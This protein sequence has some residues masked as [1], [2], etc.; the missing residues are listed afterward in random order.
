MATKRDYL[1]SLGLAKPGRG[2]FS[3]EAT[4]ALEAALASG[5]TFDEPVVA[6]A[7]EKAVTTEGADAPSQSPRPISEATAIR[8]WATKNGISVGVRGRI[9]ADIIKAYQTGNVTSVKSESPRVFAKPTPQVRVRQEKTRYGLTTE[10]YTVGWSQC[11]KCAQHISFCRC[12][13]GPKAPDM[14]V[15][16]LDRVD[17]L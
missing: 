9:A 5:V 15:K 14:I 8:E 17:P 12:G 7:K 2:R 11:R 16:S 13:S 1:I 6:P 4:A 3:K 10:G